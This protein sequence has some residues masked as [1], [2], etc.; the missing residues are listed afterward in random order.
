MDEPWLPPVDRIAADFA[1]LPA[2]AAPVA[3]QEAARGP[4]RALATLLSWWELQGEA[5]PD[6][7][8]AELACHRQRLV[9]YRQ[10]LEAA[11]GVEPGLVAAKGPTVWRLYPPGL[12]RQTAD[13]DLICPSPAAVWRLG[14]HLMLDGWSPDSMFLWRLGGDVHVHAV[15]KRPSGQPMLIADEKIELTTIAY[16]GDHL[17][18]EPRLRRWGDDWKPTLAD[19]LV[20]LL[21]EL[22]ER[23]LRMR[24][25]FDVAVLVH[26]AEGEGVDRV[27]SD[28][29]PLVSSYGLRPPL[30]RLAGRCAR[31]YP[32]A[33]GL[34][35][36]IE[37]TAPLPARRVP[38]PL[39]RHPL[40]AGVAL[41]V[42]VARYGGRPA[43]RERADDL[44][45][46]V[47]RRLSVRRLFHRGVPLYGMP[48]PG[49]SP[50]E[51]VTARTDGGATW[52]DTPLGR[53]VA[54][55]GPAIPQEW[56]DRAL[57]AAPAGFEMQLT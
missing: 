29:A 57:A 48:L 40:A 14:G 28:V 38:W 47:Q 55:L 51:G 16:P 24:D 56:V 9:S 13:L 30:R 22:G 50:V 39:R 27:V 20:W 34:L 23:E 2:P 8:A 7:L 42:A 26:A 44:L 36:K 4:N 18:R 15:L 19:C 21:D 49:P 31:C 32:P 43:V 1:G 5:L 6:P 37:R 46:A 52:L 3:L 35:E 17:H 45:L 25:L 10:V 53:F 54:V 12:L 41:A 11:R 33:V